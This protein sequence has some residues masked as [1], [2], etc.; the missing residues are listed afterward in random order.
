MKIVTRENEIQE[1]FHLLFQMKVI[2]S[3]EKMEHIKDRVPDYSAGH[4]TP[5]CWRW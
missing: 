5:L 4:A 1:C 3:Q 2:S